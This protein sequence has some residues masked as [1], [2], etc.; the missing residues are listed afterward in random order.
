MSLVEVTIASTLFAGLGYV[1]LLSLRVSESSHES[2]ASNADASEELRETASVMREELRSALM[3]SV[4]V[5]SP[6]GGTS[7]LT[8]QTAVR[9]SG[10]TPAWGAYDRNLDPDPD[11]CHKAGWSL[12][13]SVASSGVN[14]GDL[15][16]EILDDA[17]GIALTET[18]AHDVNTFQVTESG[19]VWVIQV[20]TTASDGTSYAEEFDVRTRDR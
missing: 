9:S 4:S 5:M 14:Q 13:Y 2:V 10:S 3:S 8:L 18:L 16:R 17:G 11:A 7:V 19:E 6:P 1:L 12:R 15:V 20:A